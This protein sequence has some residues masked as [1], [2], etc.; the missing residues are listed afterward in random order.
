MFTKFANFYNQTDKVIFYCIVLSI[1]LLLVVIN[2]FAIYF[3]SLPT[4]I[5][6]FYSL[7][8]GRN[9]LASLPQFVV[10]PFIISLV[11]LINLL[12]SWQLHQSQIVLKRM[13]ALSSVT[14]GLIITLTALKII[15]I[16]V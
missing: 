9:Q 7:P 5:P 8:W 3:P 6:L 2:A 15:F 12:I 4:Q 1:A 10:L 16:Y 11:T 14:V 13:L